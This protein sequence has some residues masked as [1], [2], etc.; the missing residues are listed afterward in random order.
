MNNKGF[1]IAE[2]LVTF[3]LVAFIGMT[4]LQLLLNYK[5]LATVKMKQQTYASIKDEI[6]SRIQKHV[7]TRGLLYIK[8][9]SPNSIYFVYNDE[10]SNPVALTVHNI[11]YIDDK[12]AGD[13]GKTSATQMTAQE[14]YDAINKKYIEYDGVKYPIPSGLPEFDPNIDDYLK[15][16][17][18]NINMGKIYYESSPYNLG[19]SGYKTI[20]HVIVS[21]GVTDLDED[22]GLDMVFVA[23][24]QGSNTPSR[25]LVYNSSFENAHFDLVNNSETG[26]SDILYTGYNPTNYTYTGE[27]TCVGTASNDTKIWPADTGSATNDLDNS[28]SCRCKENTSCKI[29]LTQKVNITPGKIYTL[30]YLYRTDNGVDVSITDASLKLNEI[31][32]DSGNNCQ[33]C[34]VDDRQN[35]ILASQSN[36]LEENKIIYTFTAPTGVSYLRLKFGMKAG[37]TP[38]ILYIDAI[39]L[40]EG[41]TASTYQRT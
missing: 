34:G 16:Q 24:T 19:G 33:S 27:T 20:Y 31:C 29:T 36:Y 32:C 26:Y 5:D 21:L 18:V 10:P 2:T 9:A 15:Y 35:K 4:L 40:E 37:S 23:N 1:T 38:S 25:N 12:V 7:K 3:I 28:L 11:N 30:S 13:Y 6:T 22:Y 17:G 41:A 39:Q 14:K 8:Q